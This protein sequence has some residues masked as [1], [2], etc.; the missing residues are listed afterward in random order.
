VIADPPRKGLAPPLLAAISA[1]APDRFIYVS[2]NLDTFLSDVGVLLSGGNLVLGALSAWELF[3]F[4]HHVETVA[5][6]R[7]RGPR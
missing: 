7:R 2:C 1:W 5:L 6:L 3:P 4:T